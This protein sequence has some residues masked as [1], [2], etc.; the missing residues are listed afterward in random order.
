MCALIN[1]GYG[2]LMYQKDEEASE[3]RSRNLDYGGSDDEMME[4]ALSNGQFDEYPTA[5]VIPVEIIYKALEY[6]EKTGNLPEF[7]HWH[8]NV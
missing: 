8:G 1:G 2:W 5:W 4:S 6:F 3:L 7:I